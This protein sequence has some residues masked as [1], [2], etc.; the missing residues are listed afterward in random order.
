MDDRVYTYQDLSDSGALIMALF[1]YAYPD[2]L[3]L[4]AMLGSENGWVRRAARRI[5]ERGTD[6]G[7]RD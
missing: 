3:T 7:V 4:P 1:G 6:D 5:I 2:G